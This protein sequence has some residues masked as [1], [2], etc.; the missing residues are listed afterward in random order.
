MPASGPVSTVFEPTRSYLDE[1][2]ARD[3]ADPPS[4]EGD[5]MEPEAQSR[6]EAMIAKIHD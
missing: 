3:L 1:S 6:I 2:V 4:K 5:Q